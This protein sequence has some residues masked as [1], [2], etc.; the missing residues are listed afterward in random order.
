MTPTQEILARNA[1]QRALLAAGKE[2]R[3]EYILIPLVEIECLCVAAAPTLN[4][5]PGT[6]DLGPIVAPALNT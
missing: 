1:V 6:F 3:P 2:K 4:L 5:N